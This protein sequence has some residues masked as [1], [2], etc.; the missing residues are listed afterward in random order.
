MGGRGS[1]SG[2]KQ[3][4]ATSEVRRALGKSRLRNVEKQITETLAIF[5]L[6]DKELVSSIEGYETDNSEVASAISLF[7]TLRLN[8]SAYKDEQRLLEA[9]NNGFTV[10]NPIPHEV[11][12]IIGGYLSK[13]MGDA[14][15]DELKRHNLTDE[16]TKSEI[17]ENYR[18]GNLGVELVVDEAHRT[19]KRAGD[20][21]S[22]K[23]RNE[24]ISK[25]ADYNADE[26]FAEA[27]ADY[28]KNGRKSAPLSKEIVRITR[29]K[30]K[31]L[32]N[33]M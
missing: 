8:L 22:Y 32:K 21:R 23:A 2:T 28:H 20:N 13:L 15:Y 19:G 5:G 18:L 6:E 10:G 4:V 9:L 27:I 24:E 11:G 12:H 3:S 16:F 30:L 7:G 17:F 33:Y 25:Y 29:E 1:G 14:R 31:E 26:T